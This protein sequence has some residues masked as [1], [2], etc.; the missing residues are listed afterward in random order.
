MDDLSF[1]PKNIT[2][3]ITTSE[4]VD[5][6][7]TFYVKEEK[8]VILKKCPDNGTEFEIELSYDEM[9][10]IYEIFQEEA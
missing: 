2:Y 4:D 6:K 3:E 5:F 1:E 9:I 10:K 8:F 7:L